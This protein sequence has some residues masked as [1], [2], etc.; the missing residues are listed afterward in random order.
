MAPGLQE[1]RRY[2]QLPRSHLLCCCRRY[3]HS[4][5]QCIVGISDDLTGPGQP[6]LAWLDLL[7]EVEAWREVKHSAS[8]QPLHD[9]PIRLV[10]TEHSYVVLNSSE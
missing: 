5:H 10:D 8:I 4:E 7:K 2:W 9:K 1:L 3:G 6:V